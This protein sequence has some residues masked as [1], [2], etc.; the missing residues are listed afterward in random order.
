M[1]GWLELQVVVPRAVVEA[2][3]ELVMAAG[4]VGLQ[5]EAP[6][7]EALPLRQPWDTGPLAPSPS[8][9]LLRGWWPAEDAA[10]CDAAARRLAGIPGVEVLGKR[11][12]SDE[13]WAN[14]WRAAFHRMEVSPRLAVAPPWEALP[15]DLVIEPGMA[16]GTGEH[17]TTWAILQG[18]D[19]LATPG[20]RCLD[21][22]CGSGVLGL[23]AAQLG[24]DVWGVDIDPD[25]VST[26]RENAARNGLAARFDATPLQ[27]V[28]GVW[29]LVVANLY[30]EVLAALAPE[31]R[32]LT[33]GRLLLA[34][35]LADRVAGVRAA[36]APM[37]IVAERQDGDW[38][39]LELAP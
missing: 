17:P 20:G 12:V 8:R 37:R 27:R 6:P 3:G 35:I 13:D 5:E 11:A 26:A 36:L 15:G 38:V 21:V 32:R 1:A 34:G 30:A 23:A 33:G 31:L 16:F 29:D 39:S 14:D 10:G 2:A 22:G 7:G 9:A 28:E 24:M 19:R 18:I 4:S 25:C